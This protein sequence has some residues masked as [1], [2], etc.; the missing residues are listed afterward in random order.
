MTAESHGARTRATVELLAASKKL[1]QAWLRE[2]FG[3]G[4]DRDGVVIPYPHRSRTRV[5]FVTSHPTMWI[6][7]CDTT[8]YIDA[9]TLAGARDR[10]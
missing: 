4:D 7:T 2:R 6:A 9:Q 8:S 3:L 10:R 5:L 1:P